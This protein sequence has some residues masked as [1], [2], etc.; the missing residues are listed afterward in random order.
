MPSCLCFSF[1]PTQQWLSNL[2]D[3]RITEELVKLQGLGAQLRDSDSVSLWWAEGYALSIISWGLQQQV[4]H[5]L[6]VE[7][8]CSMLSVKFL[9]KA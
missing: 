3:H 5:L 2:E 8:L 4:A 1:L 7:T 9:S 6:Q